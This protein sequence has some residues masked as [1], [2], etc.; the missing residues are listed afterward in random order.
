MPRLSAARV[1]DG[2][3]MDLIS[4]T[5]S[6][7]SLALEPV[8]RGKVGYGWITWRFSTQPHL[9]YAGHSVALKPF[10]W[11]KVQAMCTYVVKYQCSVTTI[12]LAES[13]DHVQVIL[14]GPWGRTVFR[15]WEVPSAPPSTTMVPRSFSTGFIIVRTPDCL[16]T[17]E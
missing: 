16:T 8:V 7:L 11:K 4:T 10:S 12:S 3:I 15:V 6:P 1:D 5:N 17:L 14:F 2:P 13:R 9:V